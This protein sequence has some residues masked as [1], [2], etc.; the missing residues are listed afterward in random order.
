VL[1]GWPFA[2][3]EFSGG[4]IMVLSLA[5]HYGRQIALYILATFYVTMA[6]AGYVV[7]VLFGALGIIPAQRDIAVFTTGPS[8]NY[9]SVLNVIFL[10]LAAVLVW[11]FLRTGGPEM[12]R[13]MDQPVAEHEHAS[14]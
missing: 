9:T 14:A 5:A 2:A 4:I 12:L 7:E 1:M 11:R 6:L 8:L 10:V 13:M 3:A